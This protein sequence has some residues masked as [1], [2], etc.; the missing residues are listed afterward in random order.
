[1]GLMPSYRFVLLPPLRLT[2]RRLGLK[3]KLATLYKLGTTLSASEALTC[4]R[5]L[6]PGLHGSM[7]WLLLAGQGLL[8]YRMTTVILRPMSLCDLCGLDGSERRGEDRGDEDICVH[9]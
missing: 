9:C 4:V 8:M 5:A 7:E 6:E 2:S 3:S 1:M